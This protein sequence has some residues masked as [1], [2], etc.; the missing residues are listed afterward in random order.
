MAVGELRWPVSLAYLLCGL[1]LLLCL[2]S[3]SRPAPG[4]WGNR[5]GAMGMAL[6]IGTT[7]FIHNAVS[8]PEIG[9]ALL[10]GSAMGLIGGRRVVM[11]AVP[12]FTAAFPVLV[13]CATLFV[14]VAAFMDPESLGIPFSL[15]W[16]DCPHLAAQS[17]PPCEP[18]RT[19]NVANAI[20]L[21]LSAILGAIAC[22]GSIVVVLKLSGILACDAVRLPVG[23]ALNGGL[24]LAVMILTALFVADG[25]SGSLLGAIVILSL[26]LA[27]L[28]VLSVDEKAM[29]VLLA[30]FASSSGW[31]VAA[32]AV[33]ID[34]IAMIVAGGLV[35][36]S[37]AMLCHILCKALDRRFLSVLAG[38]PPL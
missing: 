33:L 22:A 38:R 25:Q 14:A 36:S 17:A 27:V 34:N 28:L 8:L 2:W 23:Y 10:I 21:S 19:L 13:G 11:T 1:L 12:Q 30:M 15:N 37:G 26:L 18:T 29:P 5:Y 16:S 24:S 35:A 3:L 7:L 6:A 31:A 9:I 32:T 4:R 20:E